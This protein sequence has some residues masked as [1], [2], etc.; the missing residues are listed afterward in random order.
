[1]K[2]EAFWFCYLILFSKISNIK[3]GDCKCNYALNGHV[4]PRYFDELANG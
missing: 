4:Q 1:M 3:V 2:V